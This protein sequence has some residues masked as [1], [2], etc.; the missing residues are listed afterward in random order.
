[1]HQWGV[2]LSRR[3]IKVITETALMSLYLI[4]FAVSVN[5]S[6]Y[7]ATMHLM[8]IFTQGVKGLRHNESVSL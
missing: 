2:T 1:M 8:S 6:N 7:E 3:A 5:Q 4:G